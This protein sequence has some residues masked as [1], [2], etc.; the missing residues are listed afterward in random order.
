M[1]GHARQP[2]GPRSMAVFHRFG[3]TP[4]C[5]ALGLRNVRCSAEARRL[6][7]P[8]NHRLMLQ[9]SG[10]R[11]VGLASAKRRARAICTAD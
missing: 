10:R 7:N 5:D 6:S 4:G 8:S 9:N 11:Y 3:R 1:A 2:V